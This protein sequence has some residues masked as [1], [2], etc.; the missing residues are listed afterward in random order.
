MCKYR[1]H[2]IF[3]KFF[4]P[5]CSSFKKIKLHSQSKKIIMICLHIVRTYMYLVLPAKALHFIFTNTVSCNRDELQYRPLIYYC[6]VVIIPLEK[7][8]KLM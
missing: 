1:E 7:F 5:I 6:L 8:T 4:N 2:A 3:M